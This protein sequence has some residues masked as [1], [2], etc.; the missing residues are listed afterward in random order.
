MAHTNTFAVRELGDYLVVD[1]Q[2]PLVSWGGSAQGG[3]HSARVVLVPKTAEVPSLT[4]ELADA[5]VVRTPVERIAVN[6]GTLEAIV[7]AL[8]IQDKL[9]A[10][11]GVKSYNDDIRAR[12]R[13]GELEQVGYGWA[14]P[15]NIGPLLKSDPDVFLMALE[16]LG[17]AE[18]YERIRDLGVPVVPIFLGAEPTYMGPVDYVRLVGLMSG[19]QA[20]ADA[21]AS[22][23]AEN[24][25]ELKSL[26]ADRPPRTV[27]DAWYDGTG[28]WMATVRNAKNE[29]LED[30]GGTNPMTQAD[31]V[32]LDDFVRVGTELLM[33]EAT[34]VDCWIIRDS[35]SVAFNDAAVL[36]SFKAWREGCL[37]SSD[38]MAKLDADAFDLY[39]TGPIRPD[40]I[41]GDMIR[42]LHPDVRDDPYIYYRPD[43]QTVRP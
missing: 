28:R 25:H 33:E 27:L 2:A 3:N 29:L 6:S 26:V 39:E 15:P 24:V 11:G 34:D 7:A 30:A 37:F 20:E 21:F 16:D 32:R 4:G 14:S 19:R 40:L 18:H 23:V 31:D 8:Q 10:V 13:A 9:V 38:G 36:E 42:M 5:V 12:A 43:T 22:T 41:L 17:H 1:L 35:H